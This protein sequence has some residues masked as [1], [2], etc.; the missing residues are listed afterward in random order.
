MGRRGAVNLVRSKL[1][2]N[3]IC[4]DQVSIDFIEV[5]GSFAQMWMPAV[6]TSMFIQLSIHKDKKNKEQ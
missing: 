5:P 2:L 4:I 1:L 3:I 6:W